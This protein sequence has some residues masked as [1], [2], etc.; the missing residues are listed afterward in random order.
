MN[1]DVFSYLVAH[2]SNISLSD[3][4]MVE[5]ISKQYPYCQLG[6]ILLAKGYHT[7][8]SKELAFEKI[9]HASAH[10]ISRNALRKLIN[11]SFK[12]EIR[13][14]TH[15]KFESEYLHKFKEVPVNQI[16]N[17]TEEDIMEQTELISN[18]DIMLSMDS[19]NSHIAAMLGVKV[20]TLW[21]ATHPFAGFIPAHLTRKKVFCGCPITNRVLLEEGMLS[22][23]KLV[24]ALSLLVYVNV[25]FHLKSFLRIISPDK[26]ISYP[27]FWILPILLN[28]L[29]KPVAKLTG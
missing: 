18:L 6:H 28:T 16:A 25:T 14:T 15:S 5:A 24:I 26:V 23:I 29:E 3:L 19:G 17:S 27:L 2:P 20:V 7:H 8:Y 1:K 11:G 22:E 9:R 4:K 21:G 12:N 10:A 13:S